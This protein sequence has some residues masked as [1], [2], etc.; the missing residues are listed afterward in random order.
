MSQTATTL[1]MFSSVCRIC[2]QDGELISLNEKSEGAELSYSEKIMQVTYI[3]LV[4][5]LRVLENSGLT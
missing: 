1:E 3:N 5:R 4:S 2:L